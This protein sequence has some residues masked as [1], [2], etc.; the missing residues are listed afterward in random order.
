MSRSF[1]ARVEPYKPAAGRLPSVAISYEL[2][3]TFAQLKERLWC[4]LERSA[5][6]ADGARKAYA[7]EPAVA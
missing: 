7:R 6:F 2:S 1:G 4:E 5:R 3:H